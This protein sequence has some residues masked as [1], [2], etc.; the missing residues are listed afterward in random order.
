MT[1]RSVL[2]RSLAGAAVCVAGAKALPGAEAEITP[3]TVTGEFTL[4]GG[5]NVNVVA[6]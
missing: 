5:M 3:F 1:D 2:M 6:S 4:G